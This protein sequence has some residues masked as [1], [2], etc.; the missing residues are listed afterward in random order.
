MSAVTGCVSQLDLQTR[1]DRS[2]W[3]VTLVLDK[4][5][6]GFHSRIVIEGVDER[7]NR[8]FRIAHLQ[9]KHGLSKNGFS[10]LNDPKNTL[11]RLEGYKSRTETWSR[12]REKVEKMIAK[13]KEE[14]DSQIVHPF[15]FVGRK[16]ILAKKLEHFEVTHENLLKIKNENPHFFAKLYS[17]YENS[18]IERY[19]FIQ[20]AYEYLNRSWVNTG[21]WNKNK[22]IAFVVDTLVNFPIFFGALFLDSPCLRY[23]QW[24]YQRNAHILDLMESHVKKIT[25]VPD[26][27]FTWVQEKLKMIDVDMDES[28]LD[29]LVTISTLYINKPMLIPKNPAPTPT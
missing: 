29:R 7:E 20:K 14:K 28:I 17:I 5:F 19:F 24:M 15:S 22:F 18:K 9:I 21:P 2:N 8:F 3:A 6:P 23:N 4:E 12:S 1:F 11:L 25:Q 26:S 13:I 10:E 27:C 16:S